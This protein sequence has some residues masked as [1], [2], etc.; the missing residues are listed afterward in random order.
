M[1]FCNT[2]TNK[3]DVNFVVLI[4]PPFVYECQS[5]KSLQEPQAV[6]RCYKLLTNPFQVVTSLNQDCKSLA[7]VCYAIQQFSL[8]ILNN[9][10]AVIWNK[11]MNKPFFSFKH[12]FLK[13]I[14]RNLLMLYN[15]VLKNQK[16]INKFYDLKVTFN[17]LA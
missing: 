3:K 16:I 10:N 12:L 5:L 11:N 6:T 7:S 14:K 9:F 4:F 17:V 2:Y 8:L 15:N 13:Y 1:R